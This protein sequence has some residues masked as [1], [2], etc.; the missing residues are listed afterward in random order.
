MLG[1]RKEDYAKM[2]ADTRASKI[3]GGIEQLI[4]SLQM[5]VKAKVS[6]K[7]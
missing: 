6:K 4:L 1:S 3:T 2:L 7:F 5:A